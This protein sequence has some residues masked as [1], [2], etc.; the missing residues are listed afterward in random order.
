M[1]V[2]FEALAWR[3]FVLDILPVCC[4]CHEVFASHESLNLLIERH[5]PKKRG[6][7]TELRYVRT[8]GLSEEVLRMRTQAATEE[9]LGC[10]LPGIERPGVLSG[11][12]TGQTTP[13]ESRCLRRC[14]GRILGEG[15]VTQK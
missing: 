7:K 2:E 1:V 12:R 8:N 9:K 3:Y 5:A 14:V 13:L 15:N 4:V 6:Q 11:K 10:D